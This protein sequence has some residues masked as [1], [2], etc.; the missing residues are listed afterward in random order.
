MANQQPEFNVKKVLPIA[1]IFGALVFIIIFWSRMTVTIKGGYGGVLF[2]TFVG[3]IDTMNTYGEGFHF[4]APWNDMIEYETRQQEVAEN[5]DVLSSNGLSI[6]ADIS[7]WYEPNFNELGLLHSKIGT[8]YVKRIVIPALRSS[9]RSV[10][11]RYTPEQIYSTKRDA[12]QDE[13]YDESRTILNSKY[14]NLK[15]ILI[16]SIVLPETIKSAIE[17]KLKQEQESLEYE[18]KIQKA[19]KEA[20]RQIIDAEG[21]ATANKIL[22]SS[23]TDKILQEKGISATVKLAE[24]NNTKIVI[25]GNSNNGMPI[26]LGDLK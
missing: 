12:I 6:K 1:I 3:G 22:N 24:S 16:R 7:A 19:Q 23:L 17:G 2:Q 10:I 25:I 26:I 20:E 9:A 14:V 11:G 13:I 18:F 8:D 4:I 15:R 21:K 5:M